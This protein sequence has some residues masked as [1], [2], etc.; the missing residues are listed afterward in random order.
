MQIMKL[1]FSFRTR[2][3][4][5]KTHL[6]FFNASFS[7]ILYLYSVYNKIEHHLKKDL[8]SFFHLLE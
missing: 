8:C 4:V 5:T 6:D 1:A 2:D 7:A 3:V